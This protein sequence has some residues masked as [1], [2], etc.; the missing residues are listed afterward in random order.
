MNTEKDFLLVEEAADANLSDTASLN[1]IVPEQWKR[2]IV[3]YFKPNLVI[4]SLADVQEMS[5]GDTFNIPKWVDD[6]ITIDSHTEG[7]DVTV[8]QMTDANVAVTPQTYAAR[9]QISDQSVRRS[10][11]SVNLMQRASQVIGEKMAQH[12]ETKVIG[13]LQTDFA[14]GGSNAGQVIDGTGTSRTATLIKQKFSEAVKIFASNNVRYTAGRGVAVMRPEE[15]QLLLDD[16]SFVDA[17]IFGGREAIL[18]GEISQYK[19][20]RIVL[21]TLID[22]SSD[23]DSDST[24]DLDMWF[25]L[26]GYGSLAYLAMPRLETQRRADFLTTEVIGSIDYGYATVQPELVVRYVFDE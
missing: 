10:F 20:F 25:V 12:V 6:T 18:N 21:S 13:D 11:S 5:E 1:D 24:D 8:S 22:R 2:T 3:D 9:I 26:P 23:A 14:I 4:A 7:A 15:Y 17:G 16:D 19:G